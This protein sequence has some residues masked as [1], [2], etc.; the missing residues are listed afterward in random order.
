MIFSYLICYLCVWTETWGKVDYPA[1]VEVTMKLAAG[2]VIRLTE[3][4][5]PVPPE[6]SP[7]VP[8]VR[9]LRVLAAQVTIVIAATVLSRSSEIFWQ[10]IKIEISL[11]FWFVIFY[12]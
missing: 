2:L 5:E 9:P 4:A 6:L 10:K 11:N 8:A 1:A 3:S 12:L 7:A